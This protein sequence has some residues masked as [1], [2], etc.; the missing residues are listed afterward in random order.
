MGE[1]EEWWPPDVAFATDD[2]PES[3]VYERSDADDLHQQLV[4]PLVTAMETGT[5]DLPKVIRTYHRVRRQLLRSVRAHQRMSPIQRESLWML[6]VIA[7]RARVQQRRATVQ[8]EF[9]IDGLR[10]A[11]DFPY[12]E[13]LRDRAHMLLGGYSEQV[14]DEWPLREW[15][16]FAESLV[17]ALE[18]C[19]AALPGARDAWEAHWD[20]LVSTFPRDGSC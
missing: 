5:A 17:T 15:A 19:G 8:D 13:A 9:R 7:V 4:L 3:R 12:A 6:F 1:P 14:M 20:R 18:R 10:R 11:V 2:E 16:A